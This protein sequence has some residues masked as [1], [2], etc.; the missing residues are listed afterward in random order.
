[1]IV[2]GIDG[3]AV[4]RAAL[5]WAVEEAAVRDCVVHVVHAWTFD[6]QSDLLP[7]EEL[8]ENSLQ[9]LHDQVKSVRGRSHTKGIRRSSV[10]GNPARALVDAASEAELLVLGSHQRGPLAGLILGSVSAECVR[11][12][13]CPVVIV[14]PAHE[15]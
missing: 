2:V 10:R 8:H 1:M 3:T 7:A 11:R 4:S 6:P 5:E 15:D 13:R 14:P 9:L 12:A